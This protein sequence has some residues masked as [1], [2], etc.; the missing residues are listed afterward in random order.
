MSRTRR[1]R[2]SSQYDEDRY[3]GEEVEKR[4]RD[5]YF[6]S[7]SPPRQNNVDSRMV[8]GAGIV[9][10]MVT[11]FKDEIRLFL[12]TLIKMIASGG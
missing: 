2:S 12:K 3:E 9:A 5:E 10:L 1:R 4:E 6:D 11:N 7:K 8:G